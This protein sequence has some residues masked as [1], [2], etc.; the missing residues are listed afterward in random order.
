MTNMKPTHTEMPVICL[1]TGEISGA[2]LSKAQLSGAE[3]V[4]CP[5]TN[6]PAAPLS[7]TGMAGAF[8]YLIK[9]VARLKMDLLDLQGESEGE[10]ER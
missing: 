8:P 3:K 5:K 7:I 4:L 10:A 1:S 2:L 6:L 9:E